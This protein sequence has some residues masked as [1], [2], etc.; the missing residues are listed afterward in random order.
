MAKELAAK[1]NH[2]ASGLP[3]TGRSGPRGRR[4]VVR[5]EYETEDSCCDAD[6][7]R[8]YRGSRS[9]VG[10]Q[11]CRATIPAQLRPKSA[12]WCRSAPSA[13]AARRRVASRS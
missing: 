12:D 13:T 5:I 11:R 6:G 10:Q 9:G 3:P 2:V 1:R 4:P 7:A 8:N